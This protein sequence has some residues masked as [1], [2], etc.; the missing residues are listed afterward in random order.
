[1][2]KHFSLGQ[3]LLCLLFES[4]IFLFLLKLIIRLV[5]NWNPQTTFHT[6]LLV[7]VGF[8]GLVYLIIK[9]L[10]QKHSNKPYVS[11]LPVSYLL[12]FYLIYF[13]MFLKHTTKS[14]DYTEQLALLTLFFIIVNI[15]DK[16]I[17]NFFK[18][19][20]EK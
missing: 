1:M 5:I 18:N 7:S 2:K 3:Y 6:T 10:S 11:M 20:K 14:F 9:I 12:G 8:L 17:D 15:I 19:S 16:I 13:S 4:V